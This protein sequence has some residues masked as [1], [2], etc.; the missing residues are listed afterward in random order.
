MIVPVLVGP[1]AGHANSLSA[2]LQRPWYFIIEGHSVQYIFA[3][4]RCE[5]G[6]LPLHS[7]PYTPSLTLLPLHSFPYTPSLTLSQSIPKGGRTAV[8]AVPKT[9]A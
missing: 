6:L 2:P 4:F 5:W 8:W 9:A 1:L 7:F 3:I